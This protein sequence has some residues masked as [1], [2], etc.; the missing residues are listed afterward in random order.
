MK[1]VAD[2]AIPFI[3]PLFGQLGDVC[4]YDG[5]EI[6]AA[7]VADAEV[8]IVRTV[9]RID[10]RLLSGAT[11][12]FVGTATSGYDHVDVDYL[13]QQH[14]CFARAPG[15]NARSVAEYVLSS[16]FVLAGQRQGDLADASVGIVGCGHVG[17]TLFR[18][19][20]AL[21]IR[22]LLNDPPLQQSGSRLPLLPLEVVLGADIISLHVPLTRS[23]PYPTWHLLDRDRLSRL[24]K[25]VLLLNTARGG[26][27]NEHALGDFMEAAPQGRVVLDTWENE[28]AIDAALA[29]GV[30]I[31]T[32]HIAGYSIDAKLAGTLAIFRQACRFFQ[33]PVDESLIPVL[34]RPRQDRIRITESDG[35]LDVVQMAVLS[36]YDVR[37]DSTA[38]KQLSVVNKDTRDRYFSD[39]RNH[40]PVRREFTA[41]TVCVD[42]GSRTAR[43]PLLGLGFNVE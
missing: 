29:A 11:V 40:Y 16:L 38:L 32:P 13:R 30:A 28:P 5:R 2:K 37:T 36:S 7:D 34:P 10:K 8:L 43:E 39:L 6:S 27:I 41:M 14:I 15:C 20:D 22:C 26:V 25:D 24:R 33:V 31:A 4:L 23:G 19:L 21:G 35:L 9:T 1:I 17:S 12:R 18:F 42:D 3:E